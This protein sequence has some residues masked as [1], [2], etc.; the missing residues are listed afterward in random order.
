MTIVV[1]DGTGLADAVAYASIATVAAYAAAR[2]LA[3]AG[4]D[5]EKEAAA[6]LATDYLDVMFT[7]IGSRKTT[8]QALAWPR[9]DASDSAEGIEIPSTVVPPAVVRA[10]CALAVEARAGTTLI[11]NYDRGG[12]VKSESV[13]PVSVTYMDG[14][15]AETRFGVTGLLKGLLSENRR[16]GGP[17]FLEP[18]DGSTRAFTGGM[19]SN[20]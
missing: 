15:P 12:M 18:D 11:A 3:F 5:A 14:A 6:V 19:F 20:S 2:G 17:L 1:E 9:T 16:G 4:T 8:T 10:C 13:G 7:F